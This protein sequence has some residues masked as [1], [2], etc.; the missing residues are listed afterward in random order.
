MSEGGVYI[1]EC[2]FFSKNYCGK[3]VNLSMR[4]CNPSATH[5]SMVLTPI[6]QKQIV[7]W[8][9][10]NREDLVKESI[11]EIGRDEI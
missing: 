6:E 5:I 9:C 8:F 7:M 1:G 4:G 3:A 10:R 2:E 11:M